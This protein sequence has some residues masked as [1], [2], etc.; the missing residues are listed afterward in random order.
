MS[1]GSG[2]AG[3]LSGFGSISPG[4]SRRGSS[5]GAHAKHTAQSR[6]HAHTAAIRGD[7]C[8]RAVRSGR[9]RLGRAGERDSGWA[10]GGVEWEGGGK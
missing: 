4:R 3:L 10:L 6:V 2:R 1:I 5:G 7:A 9:A 8:A